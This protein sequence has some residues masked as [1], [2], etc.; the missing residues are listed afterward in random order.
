MKFPVSALLLANVAADDVLVTF[1]GAKG[2]TY[3]FTELNDPV[4]GGK[5]TGTW[6][7]SKDGFGVFDG[8]VVDVPSLS[9][10]GFI[11]AAANGTFKD[12]SADIDD[13]LVLM[14]RST[15]PDY[16]GYRV[17]LAA[18][19]LSPAYSCGGGSSLPFSGGCYK[20][21]F[22]M[23]E[24]GASEDFQEIRIPL[25]QFSDHWSPATGDHTKE[26]A[27]DKSVCLTAK[28]LK[29]IQRVEL[30]AE[31]ALGKAHL[32]VKSISF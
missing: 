12:V 22:S 11:K 29:K 23:S 19:A 5:S 28:A 25:N 18:N 21:K 9:A 14:V 26:C 2:T 4:M 20:A 16:A 17:T 15:T 13:D 31:G 1:D 24:L 7:V 30:W 27:D 6:A 32:E 3:T 10:P 8:E